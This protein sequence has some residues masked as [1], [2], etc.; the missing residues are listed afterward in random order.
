M[1]HACLGK[2]HKAKKLPKYDF[3][4]A[5][6][7][8][9]LFEMGLDQVIKSLLNVN[10]PLQKG[11]YYIFFDDNLAF[12]RFANLDGYI[13]TRETL[14]E[15]SAY[16]VQFANLRVSTGHG[17]TELIQDAGQGEADPQKA[18]GNDVKF[19]SWKT[20]AEVPDLLKQYIDQEKALSHCT[21]ENMVALFTA[22]LLKEDS[23]LKAIIE[24][25]ASLELLTIDNLD[26]PSGRVRYTTA[27]RAKGLEWDVLP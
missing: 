14:K 22:D 4:V 16:Y 23:P 26:K 3:I 19:I 9:D 5:D 20:P 27:L 10:N 12:P 1:I 15:A 18:Y 24:K 2:L 11:N 8:Q 17:I 21:S 25:E 7:A 13:R 6:E